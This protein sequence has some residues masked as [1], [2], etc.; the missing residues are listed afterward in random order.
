M[1]ADEVNAE[2]K[3]LTYTHLGSGACLLSLSLLFFLPTWAQTAEP[4]TAP[5]AA[6]LLH[7]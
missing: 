6:N 3:D 1:A 2:M 5:A 7:P 4:A